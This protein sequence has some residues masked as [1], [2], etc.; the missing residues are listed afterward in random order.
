MAVTSRGCGFALL[1]LFHFRVND[2]LDRAWTQLRSRAGRN[3]IADVSQRESWIYLFVGTLW[4]S[5]LTANAYPR[6]EP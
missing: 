4:C 1:S 6:L 2:R 5:H 3:V